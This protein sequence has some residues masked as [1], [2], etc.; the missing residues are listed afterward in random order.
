MISL[1]SSNILGTE[2]FRQRPIALVAN[3]D[4]RHHGYSYMLHPGSQS[5]K[6]RAAKAKMACSYA[7]PSVT[8]CEEDVP[9]ASFV[10]AQIEKHS[11]EPTARMACVSWAKK[12]C[13]KSTLLER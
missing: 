5:D 3:D 10:Y 12:I 2:N 8:L 7:N 13:N 1:L 4:T 9:G 6:Q 11:V